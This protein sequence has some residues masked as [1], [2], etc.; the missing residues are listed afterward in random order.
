MKYLLCFLL[1][2]KAMH[3][4][5]KFAAITIYLLSECAKRYCC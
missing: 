2:K 1:T 5:Y 3:M 4:D